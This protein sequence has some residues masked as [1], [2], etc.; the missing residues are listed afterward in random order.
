[1]KNENFLRVDGI[2]HSKPIQS[3]TSKKGMP[4]AIPTL[5][6]E[7]E[8]SYTGKDGKYHQKTSLVE[9][10]LGKNAGAS[11][12]NFDVGQA[13][14][15]NFKLGGRQY[16]GKIFNEPMCW[17]IEYADIDSKGSNHQG[18]VPVTPKPS[19]PPAPQPVDDDGMDDLPF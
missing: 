5:V 12:D 7:L 16:N 17:K 19:I 13:V 4:Y 1:M 2:V 11:L 6:I 8:D 10:K 14:T 15:V 18:N 3:G 9:F